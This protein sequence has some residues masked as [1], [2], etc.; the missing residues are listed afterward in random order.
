MWQA[1]RELAEAD[2]KP[3]IGGEKK[4]NIL[5]VLRVKEKWEY[6]V[7]NTPAA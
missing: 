5:G 7:S 2:S 4:Q 3:K 6:T 1:L